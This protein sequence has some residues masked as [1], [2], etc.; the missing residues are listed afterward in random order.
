[1]C[2]FTQ[3]CAVATARKDAPGAAQRAVRKPFEGGCRRRIALN[4]HDIAAI[5]ASTGGI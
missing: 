5:C 1:M 2:F 4:E 3:Y